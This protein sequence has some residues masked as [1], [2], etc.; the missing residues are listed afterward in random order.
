MPK[1]ARINAIRSLHCYRPDEAA[2]AVG[3]T[4]RT[5]RTWAKEGLPV[6]TSVR[7]HLI[8]G[9]DL[10]AFIKGKRKAQQRKMEPHQFYCFTCQT[11]RDAA[12]NFAELHRNGNGVNL[13]AICDTCEGMLN[14]AVAEAQLPSL[15]GKLDLQDAPKGGGPDPDHDAPETVP[16]PRKQS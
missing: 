11:P 7:P 3:V 15:E 10:R 5:I 6:M 8:R 13:Q 4:E 14:K 9:D 16:K 1:S 2:N 12:G